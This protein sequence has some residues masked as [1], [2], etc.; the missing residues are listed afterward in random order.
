MTDTNLKGL[1]EGEYV[2]EIGYS[3]SYPWKVIKRTAHTVT[4]VPVLHAR[5]PEWKPEIIPGGFA[6][7]CT[8]QRQ[9]TWLYAGIDES[10]P[11]TLRWGKRGLT[12]KGVCYV[13]GRAD[14]HYDYNF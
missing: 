1:P 8:N 13:E 3:Q 6:G 4:V 12:H 2:T 5:D 14:Y 10:S 7:H 9:Q 11:R